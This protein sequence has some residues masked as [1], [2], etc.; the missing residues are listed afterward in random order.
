MKDRISAQIMTLSRE[1]SNLKDTHYKL[2]GEKVSYIQEAKRLY[3]EQ[4]SRFGKPNGGQEGFK[5]WPILENRYQLLSLLGKGGFSEVYKAFDIEDL[6][7][8][9]CKIHQLNPNW[10]EHSKSNYIKHALRENSV[11]R[12]LH[13]PNIV[14]HYDS[15]EIDSNSFCTVLEYCEGPDLSFYLKKHKILSEKEAKNIIKQILAGLKFLNENK[16]KVIHYDLKPQN[17][18]FHK[19]L[20]KISDF[21]LCKIMTDE[22]TKMELTSQG[23]GTYWYLPPECFNFGDNPPKISPKVIFQA[24]KKN[25]SMSGLLGS[26][27]SRCCLGSG[28]L[29][30]G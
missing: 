13:H 3:E 27:F 25:R 1:E 14:A 24:T 15:V 29:D 22:E 2:E 6:K 16:L 5:P 17:I 28:R 21:G 11:H 18:L 10:N 26:C 30:T 23:V 7:Y 8:V 20:V 4:H 19:G 9:G 12:E